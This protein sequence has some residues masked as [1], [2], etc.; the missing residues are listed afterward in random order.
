MTILGIDLGTTNTL[1]AVFLDG[2][3]R[4][5]PNIHGEYMTPSAVAINDQGEIIIGKAAIEFSSIAK[6]HSIKGFKRY[7]GTNKVFQLGKHQFRAEELS[8]IILQN[9]KKDAEAY[10]NTI[11]D[12]VI[13]SV[14][15][16]FNNK[17]RQATKIAAEIA[18]L[19]VKRLVNEP[20]A[21]A[22]TYGITQE[23]ENTKYIVF[24]LGGGT[25]DVTIVELF[26]NIIEVRS[27]AGDNFLGGDDFTD[28]IVRDFCK[29]NHIDF[30]QLDKLQQSKIWSLAEKCK[31][32]TNAKD[33]TFQISLSCGQDNYS[34]TYDINA[35]EVIFKPLIDRLMNPVKRALNDSKIEIN[36]IN[37]V[38]FVGGGSK[39]QILSKI[40]AR[41][42]KKLPF[43]YHDPQQV[44]AIGV[45]ILAGMYENNTDLEDY[46]LT[47][48]SPYTL[49]TSCV[50]GNEVLGYELQ[51]APIIERNATIPTS[52]SKIFYSRPKQESLIINVYQGESM[53]LE[54]NIKIYEFEIDMRP[55]IDEEQ[56]VHIRFTYDTNGILEVEVALP[57]QN[58]SR[59]VIIK[60]SSGNMTDEEISKC[61]EKLSS[62]KIHPRD[63][64][65][66]VAII[67]RAERVYEESLGAVRELINREVRLFMYVLDQQN[68]SAII[69]A[70]S[71]MNQF[72]N[73]LE[74]SYE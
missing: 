40:C 68:D 13:I 33:S 56:E 2:K 55:S 19:K 61:L 66:N 25:F 62:I 12:A 8:A 14:P 53:K 28:Y 64:D 44:V 5:I 72:L 17:Q 38:V 18:G 54:N 21:A 24:D 52:K 11:I 63:K 26:N 69:S 71:R 35:L 47:D 10:L 30:D 48:V 3:P 74:Y 7:M 4:L 59:A 23:K 16:Y 39:M 43:T 1:A 51:Y 49:G 65:V 42:F 34:K 37:S 20:T 31:I 41:L 73:E 15:A 67:L 9:I 70:R 45:G 46:V 50:S 22:I 29:Y 60:E 58:I 57:K 32:D 27:S 6:S 36:S